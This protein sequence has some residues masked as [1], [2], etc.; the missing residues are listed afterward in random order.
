MSGPIDSERRELEA[1]AQA[2]GLVLPDVPKHPSRTP[3][4]RAAMEQFIDGIQQ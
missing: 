4:L 3:H 2:S 1:R